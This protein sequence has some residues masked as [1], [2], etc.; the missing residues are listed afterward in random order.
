M[1]T[2]VFFDGP[3]FDSL[4]PITYLRPCVLSP[5]GTGTILSQWQKLIDIKS[6]GFLT[7]DYLRKLYPYDS[8]SHDKIFI[9]GASLPSKELAKEIEA[10]PTNSALFSGSDLI[11]FRSSLNFS[12]YADLVNETDKLEKQDFAVQMI[13]YPEH[14]LDLS[15]AV[16]LSDY[17]N[18]KH[19][20]NTPN[21]RHFKVIG[22]DLHIGKN[23]KILDAVLNTSTGP[24]MIDDGVEIMEGSVLRG[25]IYIGAD[26]VISMGAKIYGNTIIGRN[27]RV[28]GEVKRSTISNFSNKSHDGYMGDSFIGEWCN[29]GAN[30]INSNMKN[31]YGKVS[32]FDI[33][34]NEY[35]VTERQFLGMILGDHT[36]T[37]INTS[38][39]TG[40]V[41]GI[42]SNV[43]DKSP[44]RFT[45]SFSFGNQQYWVDK[46]IEIANR[47][48][49]RR[50]KS[51]TTA[52]ES[53]IRFLAQS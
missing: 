21:T 6:Y 12:N 23:V 5:I 26:S 43:L 24:I 35:R 40:S 27:C 7:P 13:R 15:E 8:S 9:N 20:V 17:S 31:S 42:F 52:Y 53:A 25:P 38:F 18:A 44:N 3:E 28:G 41:T 39:N 22:Q 50:N 2:I 1:K 10:L 47:A 49:Q 4:L 32:L 48:M 30:T 37:A 45:P 29:L 16:L 14:L 51:V 11:C 34:K 46:A 19:S 33:Q 36:M